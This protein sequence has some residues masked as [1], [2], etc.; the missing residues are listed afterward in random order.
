[1]IFYLVPECLRQERDGDAAFSDNL[2]P[3]IFDTRLE[4]ILQRLEARVYLIVLPRAC[5]QQ[6][7][8]HHQ[9][10]HPQLP[11]R[12]VV[13]EDGVDLA[14]LVLQRPPGEYGHLLDI[15]KC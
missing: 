12:L 10:V 1:M 6:R 9:V 11:V 15:L 8:D 13:V 2:G 3:E 5:H 14:H 4:W 7:A